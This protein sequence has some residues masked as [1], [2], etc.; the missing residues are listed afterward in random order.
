MT[1][2]IVDDHR[3]VADAVAVTLQTSGDIAVVATAA[4]RREAVEAVTAHHPD[5]VLLDQRLPDGRG[6]DAIGQ[7]LA[8]APRT[9]VLV[10]SGL[11]EDDVLLQAIEAGATG[12]VPKGRPATA[13]VQAVRAAARGEAV[14]SPDDLRRLVPRAQRDEVPPGRT[15][16]P[17]EREVL[18]LLASGMGT[19]ELARTLVVSQATARN[20]IQSVLTK[21][22]AHSRLEAVAIADRAD[23]LGRRDRG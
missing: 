3:L 22:G 2:V 8:A 23:L 6:T 14:I 21:L 4:S 11:D 13:L 9:R 10:M 1:V 5:V 7:L 15:L 12:F 18:Q 20:H 19:A 16:T 17:R